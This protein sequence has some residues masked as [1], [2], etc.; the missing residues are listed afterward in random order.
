MWLSNSDIMN[1]VNCN[2]HIHKSFEL[3]WIGSIRARLKWIFCEN[4]CAMLCS[5]VRFSSLSQS[6]S[7]AAALSADYYKIHHLSVTSTCRILNSHFRFYSISVW[8]T[9]GV[10]LYVIVEPE[11]RWTRQFEST[12]SREG[13]ISFELWKSTRSRKWSFTEG[14]GPA[15]VWFLTFHLQVKFSLSHVMNALLNFGRIHSLQISC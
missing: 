7:P 3:Y 14:T 1:I 2:E 10:L 5:S 12:V 11:T 15:Q 8:P 9:K 6:V 13:L 4:A